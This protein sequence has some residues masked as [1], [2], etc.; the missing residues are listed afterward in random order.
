MRSAGRL[1]TKIIKKNFPD[2]NIIAEESGEINNNSEYTW[3]IDPIDGTIAYASG[4]PVFGVS[5][6]LLKKNE[7][8]LGV[9]NMAGLK[10]LYWAEKGKGA[11]RNNQKINIRN[12][13]ILSESIIGLELGHTNRKEKLDQYFHPIVDKVRGAYNVG[14]AVWH[15]VFVAGG[16]MDGMVLQANVWDFAA[17]ATIITEAGGKISDFSG[18]EINWQNKRIKMIASNGLIHEDLV[19]LYKDLQ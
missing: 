14:S 3:A 9:I 15:L 4:S 10:E 7:P 19:N 6:G 12:E 18:R 5:I 17:G 2:H 16:R 13:N 1:I 8:Y 11:F